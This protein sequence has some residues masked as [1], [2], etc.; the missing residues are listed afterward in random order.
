MEL[1]GAGGGGA[2]LRKKF[3]RLA[4]GLEIWDLI[5]VSAVLMYEPELQVS[6]RTVRGGR[7]CGSGRAEPPG[8][9][10]ASAE[11]AADRQCPS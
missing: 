1:A 7:S 5:C 11:V 4:W 6:V 10:G 9:A 2:G 8:R 3:S